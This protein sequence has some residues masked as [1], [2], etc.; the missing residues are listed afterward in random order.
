MVQR[1]VGCR[2]RS[3][4]GVQFACRSALGDHPSFPTPEEDAPLLSQLP[5]PIINAPLLME[6]PTSKR[7]FPLQSAN[8]PHHKQTPHTGTTIAHTKR[9]IPT[10]ITNSPLLMQLPTPER[11]LPPQKA[12]FPFQKLTPHSREMTHSHPVKVPNTPHSHNKRPTPKQ[13]SHPN[14][15]NQSVDWRLLNIRGVGTGPP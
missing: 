3:R 4:S 2:D 12:N 9:K 1:E 8:F 7:E 10:P 13:Y 5:T 6:F 14:P 11:K 15:L